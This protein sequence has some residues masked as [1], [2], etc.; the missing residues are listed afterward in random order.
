MSVA[1][2][3]PGAVGGMLAARLSAAGEQVLCVARPA[4]VRAISDEGLALEHRGSVLRAHPRAVEEL[5]ESVDVLLVTV[6]A[7]QL[8]AALRRVRAEP[9]LALP[10]LNGLE[11]METLRARFFRVA[12]GTIGRLEAYREAPTLIV[13]KS[14]SALVTIE[15]GECI[16]ALE[17]AGLEVRPDGSEKD[18][19]WEKLARLAPLAALTA[20]E[21]RTVGELRGDPRLAA[22]VEEACAVALAD[23]AHTSAADQLAIIDAMPAD[24]TTSAARDVAAGRPSELDALT[25][26]VVRAGRRLGIPTPIL[27]ELLERCRG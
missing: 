10:L 4:T 12:A 8:E 6:K 14:P 15:D 7:P 5:D 22:G 19:L 11:H 23:G 20:V 2:L 18:V 27:E 24:L 1:V 21:Q 17:Q 9:G 13:Q 25:G 16:P 26:A 3:G